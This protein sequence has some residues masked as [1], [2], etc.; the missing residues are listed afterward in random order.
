MNLDDSKIIYIST[1]LILLLISVSPLIMLSFPRK[2]EPFFTLS[3]LGNDSK[4]DNYFPDNNQNIEIGN[5]IKWVMYLYN[6]MGESKYISVRIKLLNSTMTAP[7]STIS[8]PSP[9]LPIYEYGRILLHNETWI[10]PFEW[11]VLKVIENN[12]SIIIKNI[13]INDE[14]V[15]A[16]AVSIT[17]NFRLVIELWMWNTNTR[18]FIFGWSTESIYGPWNQIWFNV[19]T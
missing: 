12:N 13:V 18:D 2:I 14:I 19:S 15:E 3:L 11:S 5:Q 17:G 6:H 4:I 9:Y 1:C 16:N 8:K 7:N 10:Y